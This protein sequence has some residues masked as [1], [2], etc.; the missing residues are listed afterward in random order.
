MDV[1]LDNQVA[2]SSSNEY[3]AEVASRLGKAYQLAREHLGT[4]AV[5]SKAWYDRK[6]KQQLFEVGESIGVLDQQGY[7]KQTPKW[8]LPYTQIGKIT[9]RLNDVTHIVTAPALERTTHST[10]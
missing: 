5:Y 9:R 6:V 7:A 10:C 2:S 1:L 8:Q 3:A 4:A